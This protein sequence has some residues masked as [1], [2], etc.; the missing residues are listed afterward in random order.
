MDI[1]TRVNWFEKAN[2]LL[3]FCEKEKI[4][5]DLGFIKLI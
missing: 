2:T 3:D 5:K 4:P 1:D